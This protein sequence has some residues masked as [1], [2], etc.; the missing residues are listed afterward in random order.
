MAVI[1]QPW[2]MLSPGAQLPSLLHRVVALDDASR[3]FQVF[4][5][6]RKPTP[7]V[8]CQLGGLLLCSAFYLHECVLYNN[9]YNVVSVCVCVCVCVCVY[10]S[11][12]GIIKI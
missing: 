6:V 11:V 4:P 12:C 10:L 3:L 7:F 9:I 8:S 1:C 5:G 2:L